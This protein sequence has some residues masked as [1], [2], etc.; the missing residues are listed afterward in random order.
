MKWN[1]M[2]CFG[3]L[4]SS[5]ENNNATRGGYSIDIFFVLHEYRWRP[6]HPWLAQMR[7]NSNQMIT[8]ISIILLH[9]DCGTPVVLFKCDI[10]FA[11]TKGRNVWSNGPDRLIPRFWVTQLLGIEEAQLLQAMRSRFVQLRFQR[12]KYLVENRN[13]TTCSGGHLGLM[14]SQTYQSS[15]HPSGGAGCEE[16]GHL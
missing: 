11:H 9:L 8:N 7:F 12:C 3:V 1:E 6:M 10:C 2:K 16:R 14:S 5:I 4:L 13:L 15:S